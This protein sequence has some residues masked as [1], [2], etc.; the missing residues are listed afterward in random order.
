MKDELVVLDGSTFFVS[1]SAGDMDGGEGEGFFFADTRHLSTWRVLVDGS[2]IRVLTSRAL[3]YYAA[4]V[5]G[6]LSEARVGLNPPITVRRDRIVA[7]GVHED[8]VV[9]NHGLDRRPLRIELCFGADFADLFEVKGGGAAHKR[10]RVR[11]EASSNGVVLWYERDGF[12]RGT[13]IRC[14]RPCTMEADRLVIEVDLAHGERWDTCLDIHC[15]VGDEE[16]APRAGHGGIGKLHPQMPLSLDEWLATAPA[17]DTD[18]DELRH[19]YRQSLV[20][21][22]A[23][24]FR[25]RDAEWSLPAAG[26]PWFM[27]LFG[28]DSLITAYQ[29]LPFQW[30]LARTALE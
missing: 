28:R 21:L 2:P 30:R 4:R 15:I 12:R 29:A 22:A 8:I 1:N 5:V 13:R 9:E 24:R 3:E 25:P 27:A 11:A 18:W 17:L 26:L 6:T 19:A 7:D 10:G 23:L 14:D 16:H 20:D